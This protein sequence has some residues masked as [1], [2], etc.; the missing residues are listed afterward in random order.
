MTILQKYLKVKKYLALSIRYL[1]SV[2][3]DLAFLYSF[4]KA[5]KT[6]INA[7]SAGDNIHRAIQIL[8]NI[9]TFKQ[10]KKETKQVEYIL[11]AAIDSLK[12]LLKSKKAIK[13]ISQLAFPIKVIAKQSIYEINVAINNL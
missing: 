2:Y 13:L 5:N 6:K 11:N 1:K 12:P 7:K 9:N 10:L 4:S 3:T 8:E